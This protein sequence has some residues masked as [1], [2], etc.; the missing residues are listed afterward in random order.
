M[1][2]HSQVVSAY[3]SPSPYGLSNLAKPR[4]DRLN[5]AGTSRRPAISATAPSCISS[6]IRMHRSRTS[7]QLSI[8]AVPQ[9]VRALKGIHVH[10]APQFAPNFMPNSFRYLGVDATAAQSSDYISNPVRDLA[11]RFTENQA[12]GRR[13]GPRVTTARRAGPDDCYGRS[14]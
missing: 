2:I 4:I 12:I 3:R 7:A 8:L 14:H 9:R 11:T 5:G 13:P 10:V 6:I 1:P